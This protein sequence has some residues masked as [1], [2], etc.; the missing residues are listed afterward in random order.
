MTQPFRHHTMLA[1]RDRLLA[2]LEREEAE[3]WPDL[4]PACTERVAALRKLLRVLSDAWLEAEEL[5]TSLDPRG[6]PDQRAWS[7]PPKRAA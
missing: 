3:G 6:H 1:D 4:P 7:H 5:G 2:Q